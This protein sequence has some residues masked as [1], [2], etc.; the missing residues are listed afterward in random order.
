MVAKPHIIGSLTYSRT[1]RYIIVS[2]LS[3]C[4]ASCPSSCLS[5]CLRFS[6]SL[7][8][9]SPSVP[10]ALPLLF[11]SSALSFGLPSSL[12]RPLRRPFAIANPSTNGGVMTSLNIGDNNIP[13]DTMNEIIAIVEAKPAMK[14]LCAVPF[15]DKTITELDV[16]NQS[17]GF[18]GA[19]VIRRYLDNNGALA[20]I[21][22]GD[23]QA[24][25]MTTT[26]TAADFSGKL[27]GYE[28]QIV[29]AFL[30]KCQ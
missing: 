17:L 30:P 19:L 4:L 5:S 23:K 13:I 7:F 25:T 12:G 18:E 9:M 11:C 3:S 27:K 29:A 16:S 28:A 2:S 20:T 22:F 26:M 8:S 1:L 14:V 15:R 10:L 24:V 6:L 21:T